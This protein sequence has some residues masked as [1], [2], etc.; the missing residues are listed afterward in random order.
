MTTAA[1]LKRLTPVLLLPLCLP[2]LAS[3][4]VPANAQS[5]QR[6]PYKPRVETLI[7]KVHKANV[8]WADINFARRYG[9][10]EDLT[11]CVSGP[12]AGAMGIH[13]FN[14]SRM[15]GVVNPEEPEV[16]IYEPQAD[17]GFRLVGVEFVIPAAA[18]KPTA[19][20][21]PTPSV[22]GNL[23]FYVPGPNRYGPDALYEL[24][25]WAFERNPLGAFAD[26][27][28]RVSCEKQPVD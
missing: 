11:T 7:D 14:K 13:L 27:N 10:F 2:L 16:L 5:A 6:G 26:W 8:K 19:D 24:H 3:A 15:D 9:H 22:D 1:L 25:V 12:E 4:D 21:P 23:M 20:G 28:I 18:W 17:G